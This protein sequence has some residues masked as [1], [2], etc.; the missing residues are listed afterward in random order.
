METN[1][2]IQKKDTPKFKSNKNLHFNELFDLAGDAIFLADIESGNIVDC[3]RLACENLGYCKKELLALTVGDLDATYVSLEDEQKLWNSLKP[4]KPIT[5]E[6]K[7]KRKDGSTFPVEIRVSILENNGKKEVL[8]IARDITEFKKVNDKLI[9]SEEKYKALYENAPLSYQSLNENGNFIDF[10][11][12]WLNTLGYKREEVL[13]NWF[14]DFL[15]P[16]YVDYFRKNFSE[17]KKKGYVH[18]IPFKI[19]HKNGKYLTI[20]FEG[21]IGYN[22]DGSF[23]QTYCTFKDVTEETK[24]KEELVK[25]KEQ[26]EESNRLKS[27][28]LHNMSHEIRTPM[29]GILGFSELLGDPNLSLE[30]QQHFIKII[31]NS[32]KLLLRIIDDILEISRLGTKQVKVINEKVCLNDLMV[33]LFSIFDAKAKENKTPLYLKTPLSDEDSSIET[34]SAKLHKI[35]SNLLENALKYTNK[36]FIELGYYLE[37][38]NLKIYVK[39]TGIGILPSKLNVIFDRFT[40][41]NEHPLNSN[42]SGLGLG[43]S[44]AK[45]NAE[46]LGGIL[47]VTSE[48]MKG[49]EFVLT[50]PFKDSSKKTKKEINKNKCKVLIVEDEEVNV[51]YLETIIHDFEDCNIV[52]AK[53]GKEA[54]EIVQQDKNETITLILMDLKMPVMNGFEATKKIKKIHPNAIVIAQT[55]YSTS[56]EKKKALESGCTDFISKP[57]HKERIKEILKKYLN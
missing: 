45:E 30:K 21:C 44:I 53:N 39:D 11:P 9:E 20:S 49:S 16:D 18:N 48:V 26:A 47:K 5:I 28:F 52:H 10:N 43:L 32:G 12:A 56:N 35:I 6:G 41:A 38:N 36:G 25:A 40:Q 34:D 3:N 1:T 31:Q 14:G 33:E 42:A 15:H 23:K 8:G 17:F 22:P 57:L 55:A 37:K 29:N 19:R 46:L 4:N 7:H 27:E 13:G 2:P 50:L 54:V 24:A 51:L